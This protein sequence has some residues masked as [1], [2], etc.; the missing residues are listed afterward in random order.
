VQP[1]ILKNSAMKST[2][3]VIH[4]LSWE[5]SLAVAAMRSVVAPMKG[6]VEGAA[7]R[8]PFN[9]IMERVAAHLQNSANSEDQRYEPE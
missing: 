2:W 9:R 4:P 6:K 5:D 7:G 1:N 8:E 3:S